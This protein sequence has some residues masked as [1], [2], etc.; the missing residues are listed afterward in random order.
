MNKPENQGGGLSRRNLW[1]YPAGTI[2]RD[3]A[4]CLFNNYLL[5]YVL[6]TK[7]LTA[8]Q[9]AAISA[10]MVAARIFDAFNDP[11]MGNIIEATRTRWGKFKPWIAIGCALSVLV[12]ITSFS[13]TLQGWAYVAAFGVLYFAYSITYT[14]NDIAYWG[15]VPSLARRADDR[16]RLTSRTV[17]FAGVGQFLGGIVIPTFTAGSLVIGGNAVTAYRVVVLLVCALFA[18]TQ[19]VTLLLV[20]E[21]ARGS[22][23]PAEKVSLKKTVSVIARNDQLVWCAVIFLIFSVAQTL[24]GAGL[25]VTYLYF[26]FGY[27]GLLL[28]IFSILGNLAAAVLMIVFA[29]LS[30]KFS[31]ARLVRLGVVMSAAGYVCILISG[32]V[33][34][35]GLWTFKFAMLTVSNLFAML[36]QTL[37]YLILIICIANTIEYNEWKTGRREE[38]IIFSVRPFITKF[39]G[40]L[41][42]LMVLVIY[43]AVGVRNVTNQ[44]SDL[45]NAASQ[46]AITAAEKASQI[47]GVLAGVPGGQS[48]ALLVCMTLI[49]AALLL[50][51]YAIYRKKYTITEEAYETMLREIAARRTDAPGRPEGNG[52]EPA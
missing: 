14:M 40:A 49:P 12:F 45:E 17:L 15:M 21:P 28:S 22:E 4:F 1:A 42:Q 43:M 20:R 51:A 26:E 48:A 35:S 46:G 8:A 2:G 41:V 6:F 50:A 5:T 52:E 36:G 30:D 29:R 9:F 38:G 34:P 10:I 19:L 16:N 18:G 27:N 44:I 32:L 13:T 11:I 47:E 31:R 39:S 24:M 23:P 37:V 25:S 33:I 7:T 3:M